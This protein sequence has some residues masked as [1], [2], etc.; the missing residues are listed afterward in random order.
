MIYYIAPHGADPNSL[1]ESDGVHGTLRKEIIR[2]TGIEVKFISDFECHKIVNPILV[3][4]DESSPYIQEQLAKFPRE[5]CFLLTYEPPVIRPDFYDRNLLKTFGKVF[6]SVDDFVDG[7][8]FIKF[9]YPCS[10]TIAK[11]IPDFNEKNFLCLI[12]SNKMSPYPNELYTERRRAIQFYTNATKGFDLYGNWQGIASWK[13]WA[14]DKYNII[15]N[16]KFSLSYENMGNQRGY[17]SEKIHDS[18][19]G[20]CVPVYLGATNVTDHIPKEC[21]IDRRDFSSDK[22]VFEFMKGIDRTRF[23]AYIEAQRRYMK[24]PSAQQFTVGHA[25]ATVLKYVLAALE[26]K[27]VE[28]L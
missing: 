22:E 11:N 24:S 12:N 4:C 10:M 7:E 1:Y 6:I 17:I 9:N 13:G 15:K 19:G 26:S 5:K 23:Y 8:S 28:G 20:E 3:I 16:Y 27:P 18:M 21:F 2:K 25:V 14:H